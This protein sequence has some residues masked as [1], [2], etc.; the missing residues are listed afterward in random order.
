MENELGISV[1][2]SEKP[3]KV[4]LKLLNSKL[5]VVSGVNPVNSINEEADFYVRW[6]GGGG[7][8]ELIVFRLNLCIFFTQ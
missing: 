6:R 4:I 1:K 3:L 2:L 7:C 5:F 8:Q